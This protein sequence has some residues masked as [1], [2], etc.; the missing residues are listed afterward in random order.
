MR[1]L[2]TYLVAFLAISPLAGNADPIILT[3]SCDDNAALT[4]TIGIDDLDI[5]GTLYDV[6]FISDTYNL[7]FANAVPSFLGDF[8]AAGAAASA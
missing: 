8:A 2:T 6:D 7:I 5:S 3:Q 1:Q 4:C